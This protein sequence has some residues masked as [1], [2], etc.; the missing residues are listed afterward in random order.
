MARGRVTAAY[1]SW[2]AVPFC[3]VLLVVGPSTALS[4]C[5]F[6]AF[7]ARSPSVSSKPAMS[8][9]VSC[10]FLSA[11]VKKDYGMCHNKRCSFFFIVLMSR[12]GGGKPKWYQHC[13]WFICKGLQ[14]ITLPLIFLLHKKGNYSASGLLFEVPGCVRTEEDKYAK[15]NKFN[16]PR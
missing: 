3:L 11:G 8:F 5:Y 2:L 14:R 16:A 4:Q 9:P 7:R 6:A 1:D 10:S 15:E 12:G 13:F